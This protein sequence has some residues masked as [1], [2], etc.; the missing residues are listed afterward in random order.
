MKNWKSV[1]QENVNAIAVNI[2]CQF[3]AL[4]RKFACHERKVYLSLRPMKYLSAILSLY[5]LALAMLPCMD[6]AEWCLSTETTGDRMEL[7]EA[8]QHDHSNDLED[9]C[10]PLCTCSCCHINLRTPLQ[11]E[12]NLAPPQ[13]I[14]NDSPSLISTLIDLSAVTDIWQPPRSIG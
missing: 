8:G 7:A 12:L 14:P 11:W 1:F 10:S 13:L 3:H 2:T 5:I 6:K 4:K 9:F